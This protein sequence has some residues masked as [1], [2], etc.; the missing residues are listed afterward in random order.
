[1]RV[2]PGPSTGG[3]HPRRQGAPRGMNDLPAWPANGER[4]AVEDRRLELL[5]VV[6]PVYNEEATL[7]EFYT[8]VCGAL[9]GVPFELVLVDD[10]SGDGS[11]AALARLAS[12]DPRV[13]VVT[14][15][16]NFGHQTA[17]TA[18]LDHASGDAVVMMDGDLQDPPDLI[19][20]M[21]DHWRTGCDVVYA[22]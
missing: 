20:T 21:L 4:R 10:G 18:G 12:H 6:A 8:Q 5:S 3:L 22:V 14:L 9:E 15:S 13:R 11:P 2:H 19:P 16:R 1:H 17:L 7:E